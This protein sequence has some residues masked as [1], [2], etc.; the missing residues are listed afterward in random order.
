[1]L[2][3]HLYSYCSFTRKPLYYRPLKRLWPSPCVNKWLP[4]AD[5][6]SDN[7]ILQPNPLMVSIVP[8]H[9]ELHT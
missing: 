8:D 2:F 1:M 9:R 5:F 6:H 4:A 3:Q 7:L